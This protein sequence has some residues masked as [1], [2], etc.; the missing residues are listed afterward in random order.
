MVDGVDA[1]RARRE[2]EDGDVD[3]LDVRLPRPNHGELPLGLD[4]I[5]LGD[6][7]G[8]LGAPTLAGAR[9]L[10]LGHRD[11]PSLLHNEPI[12]SRQN[13]RLRAVKHGAVAAPQLPALAA[14]RPAR[15]GVLK[16]VSGRE[17]GPRFARHKPQ[18]PVVHVDGPAALPGG[19][20]GDSRDVRTS[21]APTANFELLRGQYHGLS[22]RRR[23]TGW[24]RHEIGMGAGIHSNFG[25]F[26]PLW[27][28]RNGI[29][30]E[31]RE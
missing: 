3:P 9:R 22:S 14:R 6:R 15:D 11:A 26:C 2:E 21:D 16:D 12:G 1:E 13:P 24:V 25:Y 5:V 20:A 8:A 27:L 28:R 30:N 7:V 31:P 29:R 10:D 17:R 23:Y 4:A 19:E 18:L